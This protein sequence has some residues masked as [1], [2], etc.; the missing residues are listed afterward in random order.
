MDNNLLRKL[1][2]TEIEILEVFD[3]FCRVNRIKYSLYSGTALGAIRH[4]GFIPWDDDVDVCMDR[5]DYELF[6]DIWDERGIEGYY[7]QSTRDFDSTINHSK[8]RKNNT[9]LASKAEMDLPGHHGIW[10]DIFPI[11]KVPLSRIKRKKV[12]I[13]ALI[14]MVYTRRY[15]IK[16]KGKI[17][18]IISK[19]MLAIPKRFQKIIKDNCDKEI[20]RYSDL[21]EDY[22]LMGFSC[23]EDLKVVY[24][25][26][27]MDE[28]QDV[29]FNGKTFKICK[30]YH[31][32][33]SALYGNYMQLP[34]EED[35]ICKHNPEVIELG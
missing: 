22:T 3:K 9:V 12:L 35:R 8:L 5:E 1:Q 29:L 2:K 28:I 6:L 19:I 31:S 20:T 33:L 4:K 14:G 7:L 34:P 24:P 11:D 17:L 25:S 30:D 10:I 26:D 23:P 32:M 18:E 15:P 13:V 27:M 16:T 21:Q